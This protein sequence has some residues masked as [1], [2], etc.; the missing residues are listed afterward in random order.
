MYGFEKICDNYAKRVKRKMSDPEKVESILTHAK[1]SNEVQIKVEQEFDKSWSKYF[2]ET[3]LIN[4]TYKDL[5]KKEVF[6]AILQ[7]Y[8]E[9]FTNEKVT[10]ISDLNVFDKFL[11]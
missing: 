9:Q 10:I 11:Y 8:E 6:E 3:K 5:K 1:N 7:R 4:H 2:G